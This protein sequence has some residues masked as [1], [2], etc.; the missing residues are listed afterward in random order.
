M[1][2]PLDTESSSVEESEGLERE[3]GETNVLGSMARS[4]RSNDWNIHSTPYIR[5][6]RQ[7]PAATIEEFKTIE[8]T[9]YLDLNMLK[10]IHDMSEDYKVH[11]SVNN[12]KI[13]KLAKL[14]KSTDTIEP[15]LTKDNEEEVNRTNPFKPNYVGI[16]PTK[17][18]MNK[19]KTKLD[20]S[21]FNNKTSEHHKEKNKHN[22]TINSRNINKMTTTM[23]SQVSPRSAYTSALNFTENA[24]NRQKLVKTNRSIK[25]NQGQATHMSILERRETKNWG[26]GG[27]TKGNLSYDKLIAA[28]NL[29]HPRQIRDGVPRQIPICI[30][31]GGLVCSKKEL[32]GIDD[33][34]IAVS[35]YFKLLKSLIWFFLICSMLCIPLYF[36]YSCGNVSRQASSSLQEY[37]SEWTL[38]NIGESSYQ[39]K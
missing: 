5:N 27:G 22:I 15:K 16:A 19:R 35:I 13:S 33:L 30:S 4:E 23:K 1:K 3:D 9:D 8:Q 32:Y 24:E 11:R 10:P 12:F 29:K 2:A 17:T 34:G 28:I 20:D 39:C 25:V 7:T 38:G 14:N 36:L 37:L 31:T 6:K 26:K 18:P 21:F